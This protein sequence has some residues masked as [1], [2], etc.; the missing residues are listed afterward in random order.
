D[1][2]MTFLM[3][4]VTSGAAR[5]DAEFIVSLNR[6][7]HGRYGLSDKQKFW[8]NKLAAKYRGEQTEPQRETKD[9]GDF[10]PIVA[11]FEAA[12]ANRL[13]HP[14]LHITSD[15]GADVTIYQAGNAS[16]VPGAINVTDG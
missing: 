6:A 7:Y 5:R 1:E 11:M 16:R 14:K 15:V 12:K 9:V 13:K 8:V 10:Q 4:K 3:E 2:T